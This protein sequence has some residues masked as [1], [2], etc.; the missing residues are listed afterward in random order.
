MIEQKGITFDHDFG[1]SFPLFSSRLK[2][3]GRRKRELKVIKLFKA[4]FSS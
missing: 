4:F 1:H 2:E 3:E